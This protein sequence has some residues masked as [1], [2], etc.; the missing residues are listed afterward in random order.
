MRRILSILAVMVMCAVRFFFPKVSGEENR[1][2][3]PR[4]AHALVAGTVVPAVTTEISQM[5]HAMPSRIEWLTSRVRGMQLCC[6]LHN[7]RPR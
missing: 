4:S 6:F 2:T 3:K 1:L 7:E 5:G